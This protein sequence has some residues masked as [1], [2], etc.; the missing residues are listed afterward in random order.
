MCGGH[1]PFR[2]ASSLAVL[3]RVCEDMPRRLREINPAI[4]P[5]L[6]GIVARLH[7]KDPASRFATAKEVARLLRRGLT[8]VQTGAES[9]AT[10]ETLVPR[11][12]ARQRRVVA[13]VA[14]LAGAL[15]TALVAGVLLWVLA[16]S[17]DDSG[18]KETPPAGA[19]A[20]PPAAKGPVLLRPS[21]SLKQHTAGVQTLAFSPDG[22]TLA[23]GGFDR[24]ILLWDTRTWKPREP[25]EGHTRE[26]TYLAF[27]P[28]GRQLASVASRPDSCAVRLW[29]VASGQLAGELGGPVEEGM[30][31][32]A[33]SPDGR[34][35]ACG[36]LD[37]SLYLWDVAARKEKHVIP[38]V[39]EH[40]VRGVSFSPDG[41]WVVTGGGPG[42]RSCGTPP[43]ANG[44]PPRRNCR[45][46][47]LLPA[48]QAAPASWAGRTLAVAWSSARCRR[49]RYWRRGGPTQRTSN[50]WKRPPMAASWP[51]S[52]ARAWPRFGPRPTTSRRW[53]EPSPGTAAGPWPSSSP[54]TGRSWPPPATTTSPS[55]SGTC[56]PSAASASE[57]PAPCEF[58][59][60]TPTQDRAAKSRP[61]PSVISPF[62]IAPI[63][64]P[65]SRSI[66]SLRPPQYVEEPSSIF[67]VRR[68]T[69]RR[70]RRVAEW[71]GG[72]PVRPRG[73]ACSLPFPVSPGCVGT[74]PDPVAV[75]PAPRAGRCHPHP[76]RRTAMTFPFFPRRPSAPVGRVRPRFRP[77]LEGLED[78]LAPATFTVTSLTD[79]N[80]AFAV[81]GDKLD[82]GGV[83]SGASGDLRWCLSQANR[84]PGADDIVFRVPADSTIELN[85]MLMSYDDVTIHGP[86]AVKLTLSGQG[87]HRVLYVNNGTVAIDHLTIA[88]GRARGG[89]GGN[90]SNGGG[91]GGAGLG[92]GLLIDSGTVTLSGVTFTNNQAIGGNGGN[93]SGAGFGAGGGGAGGNGGDSAGGGGGFTGAG[94][95]GGANGGGGGGFT[96]AGGRGARIGG[97]GGDGAPIGGGGGGSDGGAPGMGSPDGGGKGSNTQGG[98]GGGS[99]GFPG[100]SP[101]KDASDTPGVVH[102][103]AGGFGGGGGAHPVGVSGVGG[104]GG[105]Y[106]GGGGGFNGG[107]GGLGAGGG[108]GED[109][110]GSGGF[111]GGGGG[112][113]GFSVSTGPGPGGT[114]G[115]DGGGRPGGVA[116]GGGGGGGLGGAIFIRS[117]SLT[118]LGTTFT[119]NTATGGTGNNGGGKGQG[120]GGAIYVYFDAAARSLFAA[121]TFRENTAADQKDVFTNPQD[122]H[123]VFGTLTV[124]ALATLTATGG[125]PQATAVNTP[126]P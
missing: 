16:P 51:L 75:R 53:P 17:P 93:R 78:R 24:I 55:T 13:I 6:E 84:T 70:E 110:G 81:V 114:H 62:R 60:H 124:D 72:G 86:K 63:P 74:A 61:A 85:Q 5:W 119:H 4:P 15:L 21:K 23:S 92:G 44:S 87:Q 14:L 37:R 106:G 43:R 68:E 99:G 38:G 69:K 41:R 118:L 34:T 122:N 50:G 102:G 77:T 66:M 73:L 42:R 29:D 91:G 31:G 7:S 58:C 1:P 76:W 65:C 52:V 120:K 64:S 2:A 96:G 125:T 49:A 22:K 101:G 121:P 39:T 105:A 126:F 56:R 88:D 98:G 79:T 109:S 36:G 80:V 71:T 108:G 33:W 27:S 112:V 28:D 83:G 67:L 111:G 18:E 11:R 115:G 59:T 30:L 35:L 100:S 32:L 107:A 12:P 26:V 103:G 95:R 57:R 3:K 94:G 46:G 48:G 8:Q 54:R 104:N 123:D 45:T 9:S 19:P 97:T 89:D 90:S 117:G 10:L 47:C 113:G 116:G 25:L 82:M 40:F 20:T